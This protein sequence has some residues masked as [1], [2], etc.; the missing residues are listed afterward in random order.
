MNSNPIV[1][2]SKIKAKIAKPTV[3]RYFSKNGFPIKN[4]IFF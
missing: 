1:I 4:G 2:S 3:G